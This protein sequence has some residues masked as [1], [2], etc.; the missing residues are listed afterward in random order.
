MSVDETS[1][2]H[3][4][5][6]PWISLVARAILG[7]ALIW[8]G[9][10]KIG[11]LA[12][13]VVAVK[14]Y[15]FPLPDGLETFIGN[16]L[17]IVEILLGL[18]ILAGLAS[19]WTALIG[20]VLMVVY[21]AA[22]ISAWARGLSIDCGCFTPGGFLDADQKTEYGRDI[23]R[24]CGLIVCGVWLIIFPVSQ[25]SLDSWIHPSHPKEP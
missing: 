14:A 23:A 7:I 16:A 2:P 18:V 24:D 10:L 5:I 1:S 9:S 3:T 12:Q 20:A 21:I 6:F 19:R 22:I 15:E 17:P 4:S 13:S 25:F 8:A 11:D